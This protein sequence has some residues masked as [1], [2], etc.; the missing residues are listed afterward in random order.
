MLPFDPRQMAM[1]LISQNPNIANNPNAQ[2]F[3]Q[4]IQNGDSQRGQ[5]IADNLCQS[6]GIS[7]DEALKNAMSFFRL[8]F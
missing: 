7:R 1:N 5:Q 4:V 8:P 3:I 6:Y 2:E